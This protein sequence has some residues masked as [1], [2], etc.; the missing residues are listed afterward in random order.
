MAAPSALT[1]RSSYSQRQERMGDI[2]VDVM[3]CLNSDKVSAIKSEFARHEDC[4]VDLHNFICIMEHY[5]DDYRMTQGHGSPS[6]AREWAGLDAEGRRQARVQ[7]LIEL[8]NEIDV[9]GDEMMEWD[10]FTQFIVEKAFVFDNQYSID[11]ITD[12]QVVQEDHTARHS[13]LNNPI[14]RVCFVQPLDLLVVMEEGHCVS[15]LYHLDD[16]SPVRVYA[17]SS[18]STDWTPAVLE[19]H[20]GI[21]MDATYVGPVRGTDF[22]AEQGLVMCCADS[23]MVLWELYA[24]SRFDVRS[25]QYSVVARWPAPH[26]QC[27]LHWLPD[28]RKLYSAGAMGMM[29]VW[30]IA[31]RAEVSCMH[32]HQDMVTQICTIDDLDSIASASL[33]S[34]VC[35]WD[36]NTG[37]RRQRLSGHKRGVAAL[38]YCA[39]FRLLLSAGYDHE[40]LV[41]NPFCPTLLHKLKGHTTAVIGVE[42]VRGAPQVVSADI[43]GTC[44]V[45]DMRDFQ[46][47]QSF[48]TFPVN[49]D[50]FAP[51]QDEKEKKQKLQGFLC[52]QGRDHDKLTRFVGHSHALHFFEQGNVNVEAGADDV[53][54]THAIFNEVSLTIITTSGSTVKIWSALTGKLVNVFRNMTSGGSDITA[55]CLD[56][57][58]RKFILGD[59]NGFINVYNYQSG[60]LMKSFDSHKGQISELVYIEEAKFVLSVSWDRTVVLHNE[61]F[62]DAG[63]IVRKMDAGAF[64]PRLTSWAVVYV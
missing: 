4:A 63:Q 5:L 59:H 39:G 34:T 9:N 27:V 30:D 16:C 33:D 2:I 40:V 46:C 22:E 18:A 47:V 31:R 56:D 17:Q 8:F 15:R 6:A 48:R 50:I 12:Y 35:I 20:P 3:V 29:H 14:E 1:P 11:S 55:I 60:A 53:A 28:K 64:Q 32:G 52:C 19:G 57:R 37:A 45:W 7:D 26:A 24:G 58:K 42:A 25:R 38:T 41:W 43:D 36:A 54:I 44:K 62:P 13:T 10:E 21:P 49:E 51:D 61:F 23:S